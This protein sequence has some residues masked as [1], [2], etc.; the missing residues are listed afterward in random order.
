[1]GEAGFGAYSGCRRNIRNMYR[2][3]SCGL[4]STPR[5]RYWATKLKVLLEGSNPSS[6]GAHQ[7][8]SSFANQG[9]NPLHQHAHF[10]LLY[11]ATSS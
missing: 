3:I 6:T 2:K 8:S 9:Q 11:L 1:M 4:H 5:M 7:W 10:N